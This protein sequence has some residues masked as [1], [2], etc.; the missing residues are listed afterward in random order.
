MASINGLSIK[1][2]TTWMGRE[3]DAWQGDIYL[4]KEKVCF[5]SQDGD[6]SLINRYYFEAGYS[7]EKLESLIR[8]LYKNKPDV[9]Y[10]HGERTVLDYDLDKLLEDLVEL[11]EL[12]DT[13]KENC[14]KNRPILA[15]IGNGFTYSI[16]T[17]NEKSKAYTNDILRMLMK[18]DIDEFKK[19]NGKEN[20]KINFFRCLDDFNIG[21]SIKLDKIR[22]NKDYKDNI[23]NDEI[24]LD[25]R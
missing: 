3:G 11:Q 14:K 18:P 25:E 5:C 22:N 10:Y 16:I 17:M 7:Q 15:T 23:V 8:E 9:V 21:E 20:I 19:E 13:F 24:A 12:E 2:L 4:D 6:G 1:N